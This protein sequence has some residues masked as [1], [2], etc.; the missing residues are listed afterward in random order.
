[1]QDFKWFFIFVIAIMTIMLIGVLGE[2]IIDKMPTVTVDGKATTYVAVAEG[3]T[4]FK[5]I[6]VDERGRTVP[7]VVLVQETE[8]PN[9][10]QGHRWGVLIDTDDPRWNLE[11]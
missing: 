8:I 3:S 10:M 5:A 11:E 1:M 2:Q 4:S 6:L 9:L 7:A